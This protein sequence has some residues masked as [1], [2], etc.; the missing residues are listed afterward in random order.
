[1]S[2]MP[3]METQLVLMKREGECHIFIHSRVML[4]ATLSYLKSIVHFAG[5][6]FWGPEHPPLILDG[7]GIRFKSAMAWTRIAFEVL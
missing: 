7:G 1:M 4:Q 6:A 2:N 5:P 3:L